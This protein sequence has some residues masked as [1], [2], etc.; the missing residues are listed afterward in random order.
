MDCVVI[1]YGKV[2]QALINNFDINYCYLRELSKIDSSKSV[3]CEFVNSYSDLPEAD[4]YI[5]A[6][7]DDSLQEV[8]KN[9]KDVI[10]PD[11]VVAHTSGCISLGAVGAYFKNSAVVYPLYPFA[12][13]VD[14]NF[15]DITMLVECD[16]EYSEVV[17]RELLS[18][19][20]CSV[21]IVDS[22]ERAKIH[23]SAVF[24]CNFVNYLISL[25]QQ[26]LEKCGYD[27]SLLNP[28]MKKTFQNIINND[29]KIFDKQ[30]GPAVREDYTVIDK[31][32]EILQDNKKML[33]VYKNL[34]NSIIEM[35]NGYKKL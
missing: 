3:S 20:E 32:I 35:K 25:S 14:V 29:G 7:N 21:K 15:D 16:N 27:I 5:I 30:T 13:G 1:G 12:D 10:S 28:L 8:L 22:D 2:A 4:I 19:K 6:V 23:V 33:E 34:T 24:A 17:V 11:S 31:H 18:A 9:L 26:Y